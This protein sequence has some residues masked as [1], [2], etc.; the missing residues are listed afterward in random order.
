MG[1]EPFHE[2]SRALQDRFDTRRLADHAIE[3]LGFR[4]PDPVLDVAAQAFVQR[5]PMV[6]VG[7]AARS[8][9]TSIYCSS[10]SRRSRRGGCGSRASPA[11]T[12][13]IRCSPSTRAR[14]W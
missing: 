14:R 6:F 12:T 10:T 2:G 4:D 13:T 5:M 8:T 7:T 1:R 3:L 9:P 11:S